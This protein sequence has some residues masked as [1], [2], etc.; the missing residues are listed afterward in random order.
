VSGFNSLDIRS[1][2]KYERPTRDVD[3]HCDGNRDDY[4]DDVDANA[5]NENEN[6]ALGFENVGPQLERQIVSVAI[7]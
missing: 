6:E 3:D 5:R 2:L 1:P 7:G 4:G